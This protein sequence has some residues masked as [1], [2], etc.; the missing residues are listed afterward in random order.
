MVQ[1]VKQLNGGVLHDL[2]GNITPIKF[3]IVTVVVKCNRRYP[4]RRLNN[5]WMVL[6]YGNSASDTILNLKSDSIE[7]ELKNI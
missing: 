6:I 3:I 2:L 4:R 7:S 1:I 5:Y